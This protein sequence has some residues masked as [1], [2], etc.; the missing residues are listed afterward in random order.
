MSPRLRAI[1]ILVV[2][3]VAIINVVPT[4]GWMTLSEE[5]RQARLEKWRDEDTAIEKPGFFGE[6][7]QGVRRWAEFNRDLVVNPGLD[8]QGG[9]HVVVGIDLDS[10]SETEL[11]KRY[12]EDAGWTDDMIMEQIQEQVLENIRRRVDEFEA[13]EPLIQKLGN[14]QVQVQLPGER[15]VQRAIELIKNTAFLEF[16]LRVGQQESLEIIKAVNEHFDGDFMNRMQYGDFASGDAELY[17]PADQYDTIVSMA[18]QAAEVEGL[19][20]AEYEVAFGRKPQPNDPDQLAGIYVLEK[21]PLVT[22]EGLTRA[23]AGPDMEQGGGRW[24]IQFD[25]DAAGSNRFGQATE[26]NIGRFMAIVLDGR[27]ESAPRIN[28]AIYGNGVI[29]GD[30]TREEAQDLAITLNSGSMPVEL[31]EDLTGV[32]GATLGAD[33]VRKGVTSAGAGLFIVIVFMLVYYRIPG[34]IATI[35]LMVNA[36]LVLAALAYFNAT[37]TLPGI[38]GLILTIGMAVD[39]N[40]LIFERIRE[41]IINGKGIHASVDSGFKR[42]TVTILDANVTTL[43]AAAILFEFGTGPVQG[44]AVTLSIGVCTSVFTALIVS[45][46]IFDLLL[47]RKMLGNLSMMSAVKPDIN[48]GFLN[49]RKSAALVSAAL[50]VTAIAAFAVRGNQNFGVDFTTGTNMIV[51]MLTD[52]PIN[53]ATVRG[54]LAN[55][56]FQNAIVTEYGEPEDNEFLIRLGEH[57]VPQAAAEAEDTT[58]TVSE[59][60]LEAMGVSVGGVENVEV[61]KIDTIGPA[62]GNQLKL[63]TIWAVVTSLFFIVIYL[64]FRFEVRFAVA[65]VVAL[66]HDVI[67]T[68]GAFAIV[69]MIVGGY[70]ISLSVVAAILTIIGYSLNDTIIVFD[71]IREDLRLYRGRGMTYLEI[72]NISI[73]QT[74]SRTLLT[75]STTLFVVVVLFL[76]GGEVIRDFAFALIVGIT[77]GTYSSIF[78]ASPVVYLWGRYFDRGKTV[79]EGDDRRGGKGGGMQRRQRKSTPDESPA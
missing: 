42:A 46:A 13:K 64:W 3:V 33:S 24:E 37:L 68:L 5:Q 66:A 57:T 73:N 17:V 53:V 63:D 60:A 69:G 45:R 6:I 38:A 71:R 29:S 14:N 62:V 10:L 7:V 2:I 28:G 49:A 79:Q 75:S 8:L 35:T 36:L 4:I 22:G 52:E 59:M 76:F 23:A 44:F 31:T 78:V 19:I 67:I 21:D 32:V 74:L 72:L 70:Q 51:K 41:E 40:V 55:G 77:I 56:G 48:I 25:F 58:E 1:L 39:A 15:D 11:A 27:V 26:A 20:P 12:P 65:A 18:E 9:V 47:Q 30:F 54:D 34:L 43:I 50:I 61:E 16:K